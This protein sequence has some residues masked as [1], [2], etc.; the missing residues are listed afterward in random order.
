MAPEP[1]PPLLKTMN[2]TD[3]WEQI[4][5]TLIWFFFAALHQFWGWIWSPSELTLCLRQMASAR[6]YAEW[7]KPA[8]RVDY[9]LAYDSW[10]QGN[11]SK[12][13]DYRIIERRHDL[14]A[15]VLSDP[16]TLN[17]ERLTNIVQTGLQRNLGNIT[18]PKLYNQAFHS[19]KANITVYMSAM[20]DAI[21]TIMRHPTSR[22]GYT[23]A[24]KQAVMTSFKNTFGHSVLVLQGG[25]MFAL[26]HLGVVKALNE[27]NLLPRC[28]FG[29]ATGALIAALVGVHTKEELP[30]CLTGENINIA[31]FS[32]RPEKADTSYRGR[33]ATLKRR[34]KR[35]RKTGHFLDIG[36]LEQMLKANLGNV[37]FDEAY[38]R[39][40][41][42]L[43]IGIIGRNGD[44]VLLN[45]L[46]APYV[47]V[48]SAALASN[49]TTSNTLYR[50]VTVMS[51]NYD[52]TTIPWS[53]SSMSTFQLPGSRPNRNA[54][55]LSE[56]GSQFRVNH[57]IISQAQ[58]YIAPFLRTDLHEPHPQYRG[59]WKAGIA[60]L[61][62]FTSEIHHFV[63]QTAPV[64][65]LMSWLAR[66]VLDEFVPGP[67]LN[68]VPKLDR[69]DFF[70]LIDHPTPE[71]IDY[72]IHKGERSVW[73]AV[74]VI[75]ARCRIEMVLEDAYQR[76]RRP[77]PPQ[78]NGGGPTTG[79]LTNGTHGAVGGTLTLGAFST[80]GESSSQ[81][82]S[83]GP[84]LASTGAPIQNGE[85]EAL[86]NGEAEAT[87]NGVDGS[88]DVDNENSQQTLT[89]G[90]V[91]TAGA[92][93]LEISQ[94]A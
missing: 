12:H 88:T 92:L 46:T 14:L 65:Y 90:S 26:C 5:T 25:A 75:A 32:D 22:N 58:P 24:Q 62:E 48:W 80:Q 66:H 4:F 71:M 56:L 13:Y 21:N 7:L 87:Q 57:Y 29:T 27:H 15:D 36:V 39:T 34:L 54:S 10:C 44:P 84:A 82:R 79:S 59:L 43:N 8:K 49:A 18:N 19:T 42:V 28:I 61:Q 72:F 31:A 38:Q 73:P 45:Y 55:L 35:W 93:T 33:L 37:T 3:S 69:D 60:M 51:K 94:T 63:R 6:T 30:G 76:S 52:G 83:T 67:S 89:S 77:T 68:L 64:I 17:I 9:L 74:K 1:E 11:S 23:D 70:K 86:Q 47:F 81:G 85:V 41:M 50:Q 40:G 20:V 91:R 53:H 16:Q 78:V 2:V